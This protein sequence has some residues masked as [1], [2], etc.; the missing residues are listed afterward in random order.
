MKFPVTK[1]LCGFYICFFFLNKNTLKLT[2]RGIIFSDESLCQESHRDC[3]QKKTNQK[4]CFSSSR[5]TLL[6]NQL[7]KI[8]CA[9]S[10]L[11]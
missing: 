1:T 5:N 9:L 2:L 4:K 7:G 6:L 11:I 10:K 3:Y 8:K